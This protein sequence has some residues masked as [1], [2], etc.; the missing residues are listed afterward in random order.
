MEISLLVTYLLYQLFFN[1]YM[2]EKRLKNGD[3]DLLI[4]LNTQVERLIDDVS[5]LGD[6]YSGRINNLEEKK[7]DKDYMD[8]VTEDFEQRHRQSEK[9]QDNLIGKLSIVAGIIALVV[10][11]LTTFLTSLISTII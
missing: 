4:R 9:F 10:T 8:K 2:A 6:K 7:T 1:K 11:L 5:K 3:R